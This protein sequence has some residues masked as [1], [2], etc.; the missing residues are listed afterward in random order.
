M[1]TMNE[2]SRALTALLSLRRGKE[3][4]LARAEAQPQTTPLEM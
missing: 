1:S 2:M 4:S 3:R